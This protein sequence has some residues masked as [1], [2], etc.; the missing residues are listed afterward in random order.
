MIDLL[1][2][3]KRK[4]PRVIIRI[5][6]GSLL[7]GCT[8][9]D[10]RKE[11]YDNGV[12]KSE[13]NYFDGK[14]SGVQKYYYINGNIKEIHNIIHDTTHFEEYYNDGGVAAKGIVVNG[15][16]IGKWN[17]YQKD[18]KLK[19]SG[20]YNLS[21]LKDGKWEY[22]AN[23]GGSKAIT[24]DI[25][26]DSTHNFTINYPRDWIVRTDIENTLLMAMPK[27]ID[28]VKLKN[29]NFN[30]LQ[31]DLDSNLTLENI[32]SS[33]ISEAAKAYEEFDFVMLKEGEDRINELET[34]WY[35]FSVN[36]DKNTHVV[37]QFYVMTDTKVF[38]ISFFVLKDYYYEYLTLYK[39]VAYSFNELL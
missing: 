16:R 34:K 19:A 1:T 22:Y 28:L 23:E 7:L 31:I 15:K 33:N 37:I 21:G 9:N 6:L 5:I 3:I 11:Y 17:Y 2:V 29:V 14:L 24:W 13:L 8:Q 36:R 38:Q 18:G 12:L 27:N 25:F 30:I 32:S 10:I 4:L 35:A 39:E 20:I 26:L